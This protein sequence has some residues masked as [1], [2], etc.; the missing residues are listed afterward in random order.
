[1]TTSTSCPLTWA[2]PSP[3]SIPEAHAEAAGR[4]PAHHNDPFDRMLIGQAV[5][6]EFELVSDDRRFEQYDLRVVAGS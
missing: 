5:V 6:E 4:L 3:A 1:M 2:T